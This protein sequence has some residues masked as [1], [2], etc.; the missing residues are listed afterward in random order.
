MKMLW[1][2]K[3]RC[4]VTRLA[5]SQDPLQSLLETAVWGSSPTAE[6]PTHEPTFVDPL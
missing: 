6:V 3:P 1:E 5:L 4:V 2:E